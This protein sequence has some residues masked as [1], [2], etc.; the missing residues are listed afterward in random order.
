MGSPWGNISSGKSDIDGQ[1]NW[2]PPAGHSAGA[3]SR[4]PPSIGLLQARLHK[5]TTTGCSSEGC[6]IYGICS[7]GST[8]NMTDFLT[9]RRISS[10]SVDIHVVVLR[11]TFLTTG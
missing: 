2:Y 5:E 7:A 11:F 4:I 1:P 8:E 6:L 3:R 9:L 10:R